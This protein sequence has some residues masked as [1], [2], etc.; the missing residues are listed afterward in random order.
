LEVQEKNFKEDYGDFPH[1]MI[2]SSKSIQSSNLIMRLVSRILKGFCRDDFVFS[3]RVVKFV[4]LHAIPSNFLKKILYSKSFLNKIF[5]KDSYFMNLE[6][7]LSSLLFGS[8]CAGEAN[9]IAALLRSNKI[10]SRVLIV[11]PTRFGKD[12]WIDSQHYIIESYYKNVGWLRS[13]PWT[14][15]LANMHSI[16]LRKVPYKDEQIAGNGLSKYGGTATWF[17][18]ENKNIVFGKPEKYM[19]YN[20]P[21]SKKTGVPALVGWKEGK[22]SLK[23]QSAEN[24]IKASQELWELYKRELGSFKKAK[25][26]SIDEVIILQEKLIDLLKQDKYEEFYDV[27]GEIKEIISS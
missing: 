11:T 26:S 12:F 10:P 17:W 16:V 21:D 6:D 23:K 15:P 22:I 9:L 18:F 2:N 13:E 4:Y 1:D 14:F 20:L 19:Q 25:K 8:L 7:A 5:F 3:K 24:L 27:V